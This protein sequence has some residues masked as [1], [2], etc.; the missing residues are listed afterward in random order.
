MCDVG[1]GNLAISNLLA[2]NFVFVVY[3]LLD[4]SPYVF[5]RCDTVV[6]NIDETLPT[7]QQKGHFGGLCPTW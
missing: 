7:L 4:Y 2:Y 3:I 1:R 5:G 6:Q